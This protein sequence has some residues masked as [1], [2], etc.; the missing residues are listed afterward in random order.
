MADLWL[1]HV[2]LPWVLLLLTPRSSKRGLLTLSGWIVFL[3]PSHCS[4]F[5]WT[6]SFGSVWACECGC[7][8]GDNHVWMCQLS[9]KLVPEICVTRPA[10]PQLHCTFFS[11]ATRSLH[12]WESPY[13][14]VKIS[15]YHSCLLACDKIMVWFD[16]EKQHFCTNLLC[17]MQQVRLCRCDQ[18]QNFSLSCKFDTSRNFL[19]Q[20]QK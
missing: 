15:S 6:Q 9:L 3:P 18:E 10:N 5:W 7:D 13:R 1:L 12:S 14:A 17:K 16:P 20:V 19:S 8:S 4:R 2:F 11:S